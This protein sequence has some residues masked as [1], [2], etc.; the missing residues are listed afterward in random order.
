MS[1]DRRTALA[2]ILAIIAAEMALSGRWQ[3]V[4]KALWGPA[5]GLGTEALTGG[6]QQKAPPGYHWKQVGPAWILVPDQPTTTTQQ[7]PTT[8]QN[9]GSGS[10]GSGG[11][12][13][14]F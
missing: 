13:Q 3:N 10:S 4:W 12:I 7:A 11:G 9:N 2:L 8:N 14:T 5:R 1:E 6:T